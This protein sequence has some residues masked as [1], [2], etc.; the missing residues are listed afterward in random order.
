[1]SAFPIP[2]CLCNNGGI[3]AQ[4]A[5]QPEEFEFVVGDPAPQGAAEMWRMLLTSSKVSRRL[6]SFSKA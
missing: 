4:L 6:D 3:E 2:Q 1:V 5:A